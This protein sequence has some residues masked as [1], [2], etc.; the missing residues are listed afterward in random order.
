MSHLYNILFFFFFFFLALD[1][2]SDMSEGVRLW[3]GSRETHMWKERLEE[4]GKC[5]MSGILMY[6]GC[7]QARRE[8]PREEI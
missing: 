1:S 5:L 4:V 2:K 7:G 3:V 6:C 8:G